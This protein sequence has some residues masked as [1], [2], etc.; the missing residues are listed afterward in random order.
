M[1]FDILK[2]T[3]YKV[4]SDLLNMMLGYTEGN[5]YESTRGIN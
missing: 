2:Q 4:L 5:G 3:A 1:Y